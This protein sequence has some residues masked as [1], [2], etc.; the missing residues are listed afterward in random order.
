MEHW[1]DRD[2]DDDGVGGCFQWILLTTQLHG[3]LGSVTKIYLTTT[4]PTK[5]IKMGMNE[6]R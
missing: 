2:A 4:T 1:W 3:S 5:A 6:G